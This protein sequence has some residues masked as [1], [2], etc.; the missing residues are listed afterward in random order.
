MQLRHQG[1][2]QFPHG[3]T[4]LEL[5]LVMVVLCAMMAIIM[6]SMRGFLT[7]STSR[8]AVTQ[9]LSMTHYARSKAASDSATYRLIVDPGSASYQ[10]VVQEGEDFI[11]LGADLGQ[12]TKLPLNTRIEVLNYPSSSS[13]AGLSSIDFRADGSSDPVILRVIN[14]SGGTTYIGCPSPAEGFR[15]MS[16]Q[17]VDAL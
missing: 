5:V 3:F 2:P 14:P 16:Q 6:P 10:L 13:P 12:V 9:L 7:G 17:E 8:D 15:V 1:R 4:L 11:E